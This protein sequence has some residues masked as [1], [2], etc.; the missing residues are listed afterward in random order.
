MAMFS[1]LFPVPALAKL[2]GPA[3]HRLNNKGIPTLKKLKRLVEEEL[4]RLIKP[5]EASQE[6]TKSTFPHYIAALAAASDE[7][8]CLKQVSIGENS[9]SYEV[10][11]NK[12]KKQINKPTIN[13]Q[14]LEGKDKQNIINM[15]LGGPGV[16][17]LRA[18]KRLHKDDERDELSWHE[19]QLL[20]AAIQ[21]SEG[22]RTLFNR[23]EVTAML[24]NTS[25]E[26]E[27]YW[28]RVLR[29]CVGG[30]LQAVLD[31]YV[32]MVSDSIGGPNNL[33]KIK[34]VAEEVREALSLRTSRIGVDTYG[35]GQKN[36]DN[37][38]QLNIRTHYATRFADSSAAENVEGGNRKQSVISAFNSPFRPF[39]LVSTSVGQEGLDFHHWCHSV[40]HWNLPS[41]PVDL[42][43]RE[44]RVHRWKNHAVRKN[45]ALK[46]ASELKN[47]PYFSDIW[48]RL[49]ELAEKDSL[50]EDKP[51]LYPN[52]LYEPEGGVKIKRRIINP[53]LSGDIDQYRNLQSY[54]SLY[55]MAFGQPR[56][57]DFIR[58]LEQEFGKKAQEFAKKWQIQLSPIKNDER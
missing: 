40:L 35:L 12:F 57:E 37:N 30:N 4:D 42:E 18:L 32:H 25:N 28:E 6:D 41:N 31:E 43:Q 36:D 44:G 33:E 24:T 52:W 7:K 47:K 23:P 34:R 10:H 22:L 15:V 58:Y 45:V 53:P 55:R 27:S 3:I 50:G 11:K 56:Q 21:I 26:K 13:W 39:V 9:D 20:N 17:A 5:I 49:F 8:L 38:N 14:A 46:N 1:A 51:G 2:L 19:P 48:P 54:L 29:Y 16:C